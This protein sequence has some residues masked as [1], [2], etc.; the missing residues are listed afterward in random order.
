MALSGWVTVLGAGRHPECG[1][2]P[3]WMFGSHAALANPN[4]RTFGAQ[5]S[6][7]LPNPPAQAVLSPHGA[8]QSVHIP[9]T[10]ETRQS[11]G[12]AFVQFAAPAAAAVAREALHQNIFQG[13]LLN[14][15]SAKPQPAAAELQ[16]SDSYKASPLCR[17]VPVAYWSQGCFCARSGL[18]SSLTTGQ[19][20]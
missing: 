16:W 2:P 8:L 5:A 7:P 10:K 13:R 18:G 15:A 1:E 4:G 9:L 11:K 14:V 17:I 12:V 19:Q 6:L 3:V 20:N